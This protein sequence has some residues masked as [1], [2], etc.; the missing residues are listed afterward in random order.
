MA[1]VELGVLQVLRDLFKRG[2]FPFLL[3]SEPKQQ[4]LPGGRRQRVN[5]DD[6][7]VGELCN[8]ILRRYAPVVAGGGQSGGKRQIQ[9][10][11]AFGKY[12]FESILEYGGSDGR[13]LGDVPLAHQS[14][15]FPDVHLV[16]AELLVD[17]VKAESQRL[18]AD[19]PFGKQ[20]GGDIGAGV[21]EE[22]VVIAHDLCLLYFVRCVT[23]LS[24]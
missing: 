4:S 24:P 2:A 21:G 8:G 17:V 10:V 13:G 16:V 6:L 11:F 19:A 12:R 20:G 5:H 14:V 15:E 9:N 22:D 3:H 18:V 7:A 23:R 1:Q